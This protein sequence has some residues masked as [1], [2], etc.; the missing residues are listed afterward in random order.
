MPTSRSASD[1]QALAAGFRP[2]SQAFIDGRWCDAR[3]GAT[4][5]C[6][7][8]IDGRLLAQEAACDAADI[9]ATIEQRGSTG[10]WLAWFGIDRH[11]VDCCNCG[12]R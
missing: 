4:F 11:G 1:W 7:S 2:A 6:H 5:A 10:N 12:F 9:D 3:S 8:P